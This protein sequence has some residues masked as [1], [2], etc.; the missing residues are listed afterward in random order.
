MERKK[1]KRR[2]GERIEKDN[3]RKNTGIGKRR[4]KRSGEKEKRKEGKEL[5]KIRTGIATE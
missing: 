2:E 1:E 5:K 3:R 4:E